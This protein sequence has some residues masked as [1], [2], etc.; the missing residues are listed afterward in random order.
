MNTPREW[1]YLAPNP[2]S[3]YKQL[4]FKG[5]RIRARTL[6]G[7]LA[8]SEEDRAE[9]ASTPEELASDFNLPLE[10]IQEAIA[11]CESNP[12]EIASDFAVEEAI[13]RA[14]GRDNPF[15]PQRV[16]T[17]QELARLQEQ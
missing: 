15:G 4:F 1:K 8:W 11:Y 12:A 9:G 17:P 13:E 6:Y 14:T 7:Q 5:T 3:L 16:L 10:A 2:K